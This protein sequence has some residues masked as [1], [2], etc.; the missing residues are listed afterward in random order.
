M[1]FIH[2][3]DIHL[4]SKMDS[5]FS[6]EIA[7]RRRREIRETFERLCRHAQEKGAAAILLCGDVFDS[8]NPYKKDKEFF[9]GVVS[10][11]PQLD[12]LYLRGNHDS[13]G[14]EGEMPSN[15]KLFGEEWTSYTYGDVV[16]SGI[17][18]KAKN[19]LSMYSTLNLDE[20]KTNIVMLH[21]QV[22]D[23]CGEDL[24][25]LKKLR[26]KSIDYLALGH[27]H[28]P[29]QKAQ[30]LDSR[31]E[32]AY[33]GCLEGRGFDELGARGFMELEAQGG[34][35]KSRFVPFASRVI[36]ESEVDI[37]SA[38]SSYAAEV[39]VQESLHLEKDG[40][41]RLN[42][43]GEVDFSGGELARDVASRLSGACLYISVK[44]RTTQK[45]DLSRYEADTTLKG[46]FVRTVLA[47]NM[48][49]EQKKRVIMV[50]LRALKGESIE[51]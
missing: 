12:F 42:L 13:G 23:D 18:I 36:E 40:I 6:R 3:A 21:G 31:G 20:S 14:F 34:K 47:D 9:Y 17:E 2:T 35:V 1:L 50:G 32:W 7:E 8:D 4:G 19:A 28:K 46:E 44:D 26:D 48:D 24:I 43:V 16:I 51:L 11:F 25:C 37:S 41:Y 45:L 39:L 10:A 15:L 22:S 27:V 38:E 33:C 49:E 29:T 5:R 30:R